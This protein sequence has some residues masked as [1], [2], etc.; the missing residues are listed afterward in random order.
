VTTLHQALQQAIAAL[1]ILPQSTPDLEAGVLLCHL[2][3][4][5]R[6]HLYA[7][8]EQTLDKAQQQAYQALI[9]RRL[10]GEPIAHITGIRE[11]WSLALKVTPATLIPRP[12]SE[13]LVERGLLHLQDV[14]AAR[15]ADLGTGSG[16]IAL[17][18][19]SECPDCLVDATDLSSAALVIAQEN[20]Q[21]L[22]IQNVR[23]HQ[24]DWFQALTA[25]CRYDLIL[26]NPPYIPEQDEHLG[27]GDLPREPRAALV[28]GSDGLND[29][30][31]LCAEAGRYLKRGGWLL[32]EHGFEQA[33][34]VRDLLLQQGFLE[35]NSYRDLAGME[36]ISEGRSP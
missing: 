3:G 34:Q 33:R 12:D 36:R 32:L 20:A 13:L 21:R 19:A 11:F 4:K 18:I 7:R 14:H 6:S 8:P 1:E 9:Q 10:Q 35:V 31:I 30:R 2:L 15:V 5:P 22:R 16:A 25:D 29:I 28:A 27:Q 24:G 26:S 23:F 17:A